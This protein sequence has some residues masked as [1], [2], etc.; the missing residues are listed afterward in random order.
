M[1]AFLD[2][3]H[4]LAAVVAGNSLGGLAALRLALADPGRV[5]ALVL[6][7]GAGLGREVN[8]GMK[9]LSVPGLGDAATASARTRPG[10]PLLDVSGTILCSQEFLDPSHVG[11]AN[12]IGT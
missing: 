8:P 6:V 3:L 2:A 4:I 5:P 12:A 7:D 11:M 9:L 1:A 10:L